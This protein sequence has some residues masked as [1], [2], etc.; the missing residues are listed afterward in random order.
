MIEVIETGH[1]K[2][3]FSSH[4][5]PKHYRSIFL[6]DFHMG[7]KSFNA[8]DL[9]NFL[10]KT[11]SDYLYLVGDIIDGWKLYK[12]WYWPEV[13]NAIIDELARKKSNGTKIIYL[14]GNHDEKVRFILP[15][16][17]KEF[18]KRIGVLIKDQVMHKC[19]NGKRMI[20]L[21]GDQFDR[22]IIRGSLSKISDRVYDWFMDVL[23]AH[24]PHSAGPHI[25]I[26][27][28]IKR[29]SLAKA[30]SKHGQWALYLLNNFEA[31]LKR[32]VHKK[33]ADGL[34]CGHTHLPTLRD[35]D[36][37]TYG[38][39]GYWM[40]GSKSALVEHANGELELL[41]SDDINQLIAN[42][43]DNVIC[44]QESDFNVQ[45][46]KPT[47][48]FRLS[49]YHLVDV[50]GQLWPAKP[51]ARE[52]ALTKSKRPLSGWVEVSGETM[53]TVRALSGLL[54]TQIRLEPEE[55]RKRMRNQKRRDHRQIIFKPSLRL[56]LLPEI[57]VAQHISR[58]WHNPPGYIN[59]TVSA[60]TKS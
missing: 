44:H 2:M 12:R 52:K 28:K 37:I 40:R 22:K 50:I 54:A 53:V 11:E 35:I 17:R 55:S 25:R 10:R 58:L 59:A 18:S 45:L 26:K 43:Y 48:K 21:H 1:Q 13:Y 36:G 57:C 24:A 4:I 8:Y 23:N 15:F 49:T 3:H 51:K 38:N 39:C 41:K 16:I 7:A 5:S 14:P 34:I 46:V 47:L 56:K 31:A 19:A 33:N 9:L 6:S 29:F 20:V 42:P 60:K 32:I 30:L 27:G